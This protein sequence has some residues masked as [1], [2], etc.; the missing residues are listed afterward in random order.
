MEQPLPL[1][2]PH[3]KGERVEAV[4]VPPWKSILFSGSMHLFRGWCHQSACS[5][6]FQMPQRAQQMNRT[7]T[8][9]PGSLCCLTQALPVRGSFPAARKQ[10]GWDTRQELIF[11]SSRLQ[12]YSYGET[13]SP[14]AKCLGVALSL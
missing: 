13:G 11:V 4:P 9:E 2:L 1:P 14:T 8:C 10:K 3:V 5:L 7:T 12:K 6:G